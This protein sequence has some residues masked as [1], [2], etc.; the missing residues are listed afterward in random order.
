MTT[1]N[2][3]DLTAAELDFLLAASTDPSADF[4]PTA[5]R[6]EAFDAIV[7]FLAAGGRL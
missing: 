1:I 2:I 7:A 5:I 6:E 4:D 3:T